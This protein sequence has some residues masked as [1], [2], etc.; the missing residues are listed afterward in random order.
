MMNLAIKT[1]YYK[2]QM[3]MIISLLYQEVY[4][5]KELM[6]VLKKYMIGNLIFFMQKNNYTKKRSKFLLFI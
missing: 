4:L 2:N 6:A 1:K 3:E 5:E